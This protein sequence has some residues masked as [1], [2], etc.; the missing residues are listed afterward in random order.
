[1]RLLNFIKAIFSK[2]ISR[3]IGTEEFDIV[4]CVI[5]PTHFDKKEKFYSYSFI[6]PKKSTD[7]SLIRLSYCNTDV[8]KVHGVQL[9]ASLDVRSSKKITFKGLAV[10]NN[11]MIDKINSIGGIKANIKGTPLDKENQYIEASKKVYKCDKG[12]P[13]HADL[14]F[15]KPVPDGEPATEHRKYADELVCL[16]LDKKIYFEDNCNSE[17]RWCGEFIS[18]KVK[19]LFA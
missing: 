6:P 16:I 7:T 2:F 11:L 12:K 3:E 9:A 18:T 1:M 14:I 13:Y 4:R 5:H 8:A 19:S 10:V 17:N 15:E